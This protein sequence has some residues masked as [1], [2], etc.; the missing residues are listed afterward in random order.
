MYAFHVFDIRVFDLRVGIQVLA[1]EVEIELLLL[2][3]LERFICSTCCHDLG[4]DGTLCS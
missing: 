3:D 4:D 1:V 2:A